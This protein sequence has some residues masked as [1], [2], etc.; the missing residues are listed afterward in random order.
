MPKAPAPRQAMTAGDWRLLA[1]AAA[2]TSATAG[3]HFA[4]APATARF[5]VAAAAL[6]ALAALVGRCVGALGDRLG[7][8]ATGAI[9]GALANLPELAF[10]IFA[11]RAGLP[12]VLRA[13]LVGS[14]LANVLAVLGLAFVVGGLR[15]GTQ[16]FAAERAKL[17]SLLLLLAVAVL[18]VPTLAAGLDLP[19]ARHERVLSDVA[20]GILLALYA[21]SLLADLGGGRAHPVPGDPPQP[22][23][24]PL[25]LTLALLVT[26]A[27]GATATSSWFVD[28]LTPAVRALGISPI[29]AG[30]VIVAIAG[31]AVENAVGVS[32]AARNRS[33]LAFSVIL[34]SPLQIALVLIPVLVLV[35]PLVGGATLTLVFPPLLVASLA[36]A[37]VVTAFVVIDG[38]S[39]WMEGVCL[40]GLYVSVAAAFWWG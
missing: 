25:G 28:A 36:L 24:W 8:S 32:L 3:T 4:S 14:I 22:G 26:S 10:G 13:A 37:V 19:A 20:A 35:S 33:D 16:R 18:I 11:L 27:A 6:A 31:N 39:T 29:F 38:E 21:L 12:G 30:L 9:Q 1:L 5:V 40:L 17:L 7:V 15:H 34:Q 2:L 23:R